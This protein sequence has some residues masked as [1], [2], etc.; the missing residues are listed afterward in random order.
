MLISSGG[1]IRLGRISK[2]GDYYLRT[3]IGTWCPFL[4]HKGS[5]DKTEFK[6]HNP[7]KGCVSIALA[8]DRTTGKTDMGID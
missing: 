7:D 3:L 5:G 6:E 2:H 1:K 8:R 4:S